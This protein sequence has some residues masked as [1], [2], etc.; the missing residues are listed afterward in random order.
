MLSPSEAC[1]IRV[2]HGGTTA[3]DP[4]PRGAVLQSRAPSE[5]SIVRQVP[6]EDIVPRSALHLC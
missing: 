2:L 5:V 4:G 3:P 6:W 1:S